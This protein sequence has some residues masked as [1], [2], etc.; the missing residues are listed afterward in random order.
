MY[1]S[2]VLVAH[3]MTP[4]TPVLTI[5]NVLPAYSIEPQWYD[6]CA[7]MMGLG[8]SAREY[9]KRSDTSARELWQKRLWSLSLTEQKK[10]V[11]VM[12]A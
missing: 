3:A 5:R 12:L 1:P 7:T 6:I 2:V 4:V 8:W 9:C 11:E 10:K